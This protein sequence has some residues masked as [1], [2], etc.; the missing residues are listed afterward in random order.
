VGK[1]AAATAQSAESSTLAN[2]NSLVQL[3]QQQ[4][5]NSAQLF[6]TA[7]PGYAAA[8][9]FYTSLSSGDPGKIAAAIAPSTQ[10]ITQASTGAK[11]NI[12]NNAPAGGEKN[13]AL[14]NVDVNQGA[15]V[16]KTASEGYLNSF[17]ALGQLSQQ[18]MGASQNAAGLAT[19]QYGAANQGFGQVGSEA[20]QHKGQTLGAFGGLLSTAVSGPNTGKGGSQSFGSNVTSGGG[21]GGEGGGSQPMSFADMSDP[22]YLAS[23]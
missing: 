16:G 5:G 2:S 19:S 15:Q 12:L 18:G 10:A 14:E 20:L 1:G 21:G 6:Q 8:T 17:N 13:L 11:Q 4:A 23:S 3:A 22:S 7:M 9:D